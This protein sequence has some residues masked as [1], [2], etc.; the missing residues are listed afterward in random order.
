MMTTPNNQLK[1]AARIFL[2]EV[3]PLSRSVG[4]TPRG[5]RE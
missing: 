5:I 1:L 4:H 3:P 2:A